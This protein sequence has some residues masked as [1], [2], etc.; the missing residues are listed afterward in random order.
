MCWLNEPHAC[1]VSSV[2]SLLPPP[3]PCADYWGSVAASRAAS[4]APMFFAV[5]SAGV[6][7]K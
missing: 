2:P 4:P 3:A 6:A 5:A 1:A 7:L